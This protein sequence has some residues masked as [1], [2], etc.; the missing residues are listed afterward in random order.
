LNISFP[1]YALSIV[2]VTNINGNMQNKKNVGK[3]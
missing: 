2:S 3:Y 1:I